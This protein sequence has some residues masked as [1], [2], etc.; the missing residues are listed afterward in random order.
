[1][2]VNY[3][4]TDEKALS[5][6]KIPVKVYGSSEEI[7]SAM[8]RLMADTIKEHNKKG[9][10]TTF[11]LP[12]GPVGQYP[13]F[14]DI[15]NKERISLRSCNFVNMDEYLTDEQ[16]WVSE[17]NRL[18]F[19]GFMRRNVYERI[20]NDLR[21]LPEQWVFPDPLDLGSVQRFI[22]KIGGVD[23]A[24]GGIGINGHIAFNEA[25]DHTP[26]EVFAKRETRIITIS[27][28]TRCANAIGDLAG[29]IDAM[30]RYA[31]SIGMRQIL[32]AKQVRLGVFR[33]WHR[34]VLR[35]AVFDDVSAHFPVTLL[36]KHPDTII[37][38]NANAT[39]KP[40]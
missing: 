31:V 2:D 14:V 15:I 17:D 11:I 34:A 40:F 24:F 38:T 21:I 39:K 1:M 9:I 23:I 32:A 12:V 8:A 3:Y 6:G 26:V 22:D 29:A 16:K 30:P 13:Y 33:D 28:E 5:R 10:P 25:E 35:Q 7:F 4:Q 37:M 27:H 19:R 36:Q 18:S 20:D